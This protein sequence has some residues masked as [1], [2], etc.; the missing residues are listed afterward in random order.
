MPS[1]AASRAATQDRIVAAARMLV[2]DGRELTL[3]AVAREVDMTAPA[4]YRYAAS[5]QDLVRMIALAIDAD[6]AERVAGAAAAYDLEDPAARLIA[7][8]VEFRRWALTN[9]AEFALAGLFLNFVT[10]LIP[11]LLFTFGGGVC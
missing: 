7:A 3:R 4:L 6:V 10:G 11:F 1:R 9:R 5:H 2:T 8:S